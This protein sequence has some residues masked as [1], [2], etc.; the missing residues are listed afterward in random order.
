[1]LWLLSGFVDFAWSIFREPT[2]DRQMLCFRDTTFATHPK[3]AAT[4]AQFIPA[5]LATFCRISS[6]VHTGITQNYYTFPYTN[7]IHRCDRLYRPQPQRAVQ[8]TR[9]CWRTSMP[10]ARPQPYLQC[11]VCVRTRLCTP[12]CRFLFVASRPY[13]TAKPGRSCGCRSRSSV[14]R[15]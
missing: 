13:P 4:S 15:R 8:H 11:V 12:C 2:V 6:D 9:A 5:F 14:P 7:D 1:M 10:F 3:L